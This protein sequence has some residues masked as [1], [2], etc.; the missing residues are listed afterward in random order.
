MAMV[1]NNSRTFYS[2]PIQWNKGTPTKGYRV[3]YTSEPDFHGS[4]RF[5]IQFIYGKN[6]NDIDDYAV[7]VLEADSGIDAQMTRLQPH[8]A[9]SVTFRTDFTSR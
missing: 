2:V 5:K 6:N 9:R 1:W 7:N 4:D 3:D 8:A